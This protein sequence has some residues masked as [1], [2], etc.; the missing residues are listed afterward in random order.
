MTRRPLVLATRNHPQ[1]VS[2][3]AALLILGLL[4]LTGVATAR[5]LTALTESEGF[6]ALWAAGLAL[7]GAIALAGATTPRGRLV[8][9]LLAEATGAAGLAVGV[10]TYVAA[11][12]VDATPVPWATVTFA[13]GV[14]A[15]SLARALQ[16][17]RESR[18]TLAAVAAGAAADP[19]PLGEARRVEE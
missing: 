5:A 6:A 12:V 17:A 11:I 16:C 7:S 9:A 13:G 18:M 2:T 15:G 19:P 1:A 10:G 14:A 4:Y 8:W 3:Y